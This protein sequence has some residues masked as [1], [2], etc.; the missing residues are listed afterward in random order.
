M[1]DMRSIFKKFNRVITQKESDQQPFE[2]IDLPAAAKIIKKAESD[3]ASTD[4]EK[5]NN[6]LDFARTL[7]SATQNSSPLGNRSPLLDV[8]RVLGRSIQAHY[9]TLPLYYY[10]EKVP[11]QMNKREIQENLLFPLNLNVTSIMRGET[12]C[13]I[14]VKDKQFD[15]EICLGKDVVLPWPWNREKYIGTISKVGEG[16]QSGN[17]QQDINH[18]LELWLPVGVSW[19]CGGN[20][21]IASGIIQG[22]GKVKP[23]YVCDIGRVY[24][25]IKCDGQNYIR[26]EDGSILAPVRSLE[27]AAIFE[28]GRMMKDNNISY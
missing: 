20:H 26:T 27:F 3:E 8:V 21:S 7:L 17:W 4:V 23:D 13:E 22:F 12:F 16:K 18:S 1:V 28:I 6:V 25:Y 2:S 24:D 10:K 11:S 19:V 14:I 5:F 9:L 15:G